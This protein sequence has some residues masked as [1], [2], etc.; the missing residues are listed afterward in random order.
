MI[1]Y[2][3]FVRPHLDYGDVICDEAYNETFREKLESIQHNVC[4]ALSR[5]IRGSL[6]KTLYYELESLRLESFKRR[7]WHRKLCIFYKILKENK[8]VYIYNLVPTKN[9]HY[10]TR[11]TEKLIPFHIKHKFFNFFF[12]FLFTVIE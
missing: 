5:A 6:R 9:S 11:N 10:N 2:K 12:F 1:M 7:G 3:A 8:P 4:L